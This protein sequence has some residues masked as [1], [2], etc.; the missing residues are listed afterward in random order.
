MKIIRNGL[1]AY[2]RNVAHIKY[3]PIAEIMDNFQYNVS[4]EESETTEWILIT[5]CIMDP[6]KNCQIN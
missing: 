4:A 2:F 3:R 6:T 1:R 5:F